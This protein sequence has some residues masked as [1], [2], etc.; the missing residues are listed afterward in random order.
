MGEQQDVYAEQLKQ[1]IVACGV[2][3]EAVE[4]R[5]EH[6]LQGYDIVVSCGLLSEAQVACVTDIGNLPGHVTFTDSRNT[7]LER[8]I[9]NKRHKARMR[10][11]AASMPDLPRYDPS[12]MSLTEFAR[13]IERYCGLEPGT[14]VEV[15]S[16]RLLTFRKLS[17]PFNRG[18]ASQR[19]RLMEILGA[20]LV[21]H[22]V[23]I[24]VIGGTGGR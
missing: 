22:D 24:G 21:D 5:Y 2:P 8:E 4:V 14:N 20:A 19:G 9:T 11:L 16:D 23:Q 6:V 1:E 7:A 12:T 18:E 15:V 17:L 13:T 3:A 10:D